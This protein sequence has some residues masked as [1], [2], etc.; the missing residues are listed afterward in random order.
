[1]E[2]PCF[3]A[4][5]STARRPS[6]ITSLPMPSPGMTAMRYCFL[7]IE[8]FLVT[9]RAARAAYAGCP[10]NE[11]IFAA[12]QRCSAMLTVAAFPLSISAVPPPIPRPAREKNTMD[13]HLRGK[14][15][16]IT[17]ASKGIGAAAAEA[18]AEEGCHLRLAARSGE[19]LKALADRLR[20]QH[21]IDATTHVTDLRKG[22]D[23]ARLA[24]DAS[25][26]DILVN[27]AGD[28]PGGSLAK[29][30]EV[31]WRHAWQ[32]KV[33]GY[34]DLTRL[35]YAQMKAR[36]GGVIIND[37]GAAGERFDADYIA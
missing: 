15:V 13:L 27:N 35:V 36:G 9:C 14:R 12:A 34:I 31:T 16:L 1:M 24:K 10:C 28:I 11:P 18:F 33:F 8:N 29:V 5:A 26:I 21:Q 6:G 2:T 17:G 22:E 20:S 30:D 25:D 32:L 23:I 4:A 37:I 19:A 3:F 7:L